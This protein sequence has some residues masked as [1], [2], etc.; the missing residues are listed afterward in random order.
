MFRFTLHFKLIK[1]FD[2]L[3]LSFDRSIA[4]HTP[5]T[6]C[7]S[8]WNTWNKYTQILCETA[9]RQK[10]S[11]HIKT[12]SQKQTQSEYRERNQ[13]RPPTVID[14]TLFVHLVRYM[15][16]FFFEFTAS[17][18]V[19]SS[20]SNTNKLVAKQIGHLVVRTNRLAAHGV[21]LLVAS[22]SCARRACSNARLWAGRQ[23]TRRIHWHT[24]QSAFRPFLKAF[25]QRISSRWVSTCFLCCPC[26]ST[27]SCSSSSS[28]LINP[29]PF[30]EHFEMDRLC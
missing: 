3:C 28:Y 29:W 17:S 19:T 18:N 24:L 23:Q 2:P 15:Q 7:Q 27:Q 21:R 11:T 30:V 13:V 14:H 20:D 9:R 6:S 22:A 8:K 1:T 5:S 26:S 12:R 4:G 10:R 25:I 16:L